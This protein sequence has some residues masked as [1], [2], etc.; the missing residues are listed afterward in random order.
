[1]KRR[2]ERY[3]LAI[4]RAGDLPAG[5]AVFVAADSL[6]QGRLKARRLGFGELVF[7]EFRKPRNPGFHRLAHAIGGMAAENLDEF[8]G[9]TS[10]QALKRLQM[11]SG[12]GC[13]EIAYKTHGQYIVQ[14]IPLS[15]SYESMDD[16]EFQAVM[17]AICKKLTDYWPDCTEDDILK[18][19]DE[20]ERAA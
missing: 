13:E 20:W 17:K 15:L 5:Q 16:L 10:H 14:R 7:A 4:A 3:C 18:M 2:P 8:A 6:T 11:E 19:A 12:A 1:M 9:M